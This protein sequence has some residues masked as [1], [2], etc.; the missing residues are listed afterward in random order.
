MLTD[1]GTDFSTIWSHK[2]LL[3]SSTVCGLT[4]ISSSFA[5]GLG[6]ELWK[7]HSVNCVGV[8]L[9][10]RTDTSNSVKPLTISVATKLKE[11]NGWQ[12]GLEVLMKV[13][14]V[15]NVGIALLFHFQLHSDMENAMY[16]LQKYE[17]AL[18]KIDAPEDELEK[19]LSAQET[20][21]SYFH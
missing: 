12:K 11:K 10:S 13:V 15:K 19:I 4:A 18:R 14:T 5:K 6:G 8:R 20:L 3:H 9:F 16:I 7:D 1:V 17:E 2:R 21:I